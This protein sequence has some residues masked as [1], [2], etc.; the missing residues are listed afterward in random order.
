[1]ARYLADTSAWI[2]AQRRNAPTELRERFSELLI[3]DE[4]ATC[5]PV[6]W[7]LLH[8]TNNAAEFKA[9]REDLEVLEQ[10]V[11]D[12]SGWLRAFDVCQALADRSALHRAIKLPDALIA[13]SAERAELT[14]IHYDKDF[15]LITGVTGQPCEW[16]APQGSL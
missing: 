4:I 14:V 11:V 10:A 16:I 12:E 5:G 6:K 15:D 9:R 7:E 1:V 2:H 13:A 3:A 8:N